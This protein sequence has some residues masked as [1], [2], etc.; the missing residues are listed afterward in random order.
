VALGLGV[1]G[2]RSGHARTSIPRSLVPLLAAFV[3]ASCGYIGDPL[4]PLA[5]I[6]GS[7]ADLAAVQRGNRIII[8]FTPPERT[9]EGRP[10]K[11]PLQFDLRIGPA[12]TPFTTPAWAAAATRIPPP[13]VDNGLAETEIPST[14]WTGR[15]VALAVRSIG[16]NRKES[17]WSNFVNLT[18]VPPPPR[19]EG[20]TAENTADG[21]RLAWKGG[22]AGPSGDYVVLRRT[23]PDRNFIQLAEAQQPEYL[24]RASE[25]G[26]TYTYLVQRI[27]RVGEGR[28]AQSELSEPAAITPQDVFPPA[29]PRGLRAIAG[30]G[31]IEL[32]WDANSEPDLAGYRIYRAA[33]GADFQ[34]LADVSTVP[35]Y[36]DRQVESGKAYRYAITA[37]DRAGNESARSP[38]VEGAVQ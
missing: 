1:R 16:S 31:S 19:P 12:V 10:V 26:K 34:K 11:T 37:V 35:A 28:A 24:D 8:H 4:P 30:P 22:P 33:P 25:F 15:E 5:N 21:V 23:S 32:A 36:T 18:V 6:P 7:V 9:T 38:V 20:L 13:E 14:A 2:Q 3:L 29:A 17:E 27:A